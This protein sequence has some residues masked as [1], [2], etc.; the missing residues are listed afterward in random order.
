MGVVSFGTVLSLCASYK[1]LR[2]QCGY[3]NC[4][5]NNCCCTIVLM[6]ASCNDCG[7]LLQTFASIL[8]FS[9]AYCMYA[10]EHDTYTCMSPHT[11]KDMSTVAWSPCI[12]GQLCLQVLTMN[13]PLFWRPYRGMVLQ[14]QNTSVRDLPCAWNKYS[15]HDFGTWRTLGPWVGLTRK[16]V[17]QCKS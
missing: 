4:C 2:G 17:Q 1:L 5:C 16:K 3:G 15:V 13:S 14:A 11:L 7:L 8:V 9:H 10:C 6:Y 12:V